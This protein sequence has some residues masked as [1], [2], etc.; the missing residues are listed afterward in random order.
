MSAL[1]LEA[2][3]NC[4]EGFVPTVLATRDTEGVVPSHQYPIR[5]IKGSFRPAAIGTRV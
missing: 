4:L 3:R 2:I 1:G 5:H